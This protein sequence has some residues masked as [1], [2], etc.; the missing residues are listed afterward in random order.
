[1]ENRLASFCFSRVVAITSSSN[2]LTLQLKIREDFY[3]LN[4]EISG[5]LTLWLQSNFPFFQFF[6]FT[7]FKF[8]RL[9]GNDELRHEDAIDDPETI[10]SMVDMWVKFENK[11]W[12]FC[13]VEAYLETNHIILKIKLTFKITVDIKNKLT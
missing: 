8:C 6:F 13:K 12:K 9:S 2:V 4:L 3:W 1:M 7:W 5:S 10:S 11:R